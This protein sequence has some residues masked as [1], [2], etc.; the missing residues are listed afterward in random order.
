LIYDR[1][2]RKINYLRISVTDRCNLRCIYCMPEKGI[3]KIKHEDMLSFE[4]IFE[5]TK[6]AVEMGINKVRLTGGEPLIRRDIVVL[7][8]MLSSI[9][10]IKDLAMTTNGIILDKYAL[11]LLKAG[12]QRVNISLDTLDPQRYNE[13]TCGGDIR[14]VL[15]GIKAAKSVGLIPIKLNCVVKKSSDENDA[16]MVK[17]FAKENGLKA[18]F[19]RQMNMEKGLFWP[20]EGGEGGD[21]KRCNRLRLSSDGRIFPCLFND[22]SFSIKE[23]GIEQAIKMAVKAKPKS[24]LWSNHN[25]LGSLGG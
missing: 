6:K 8:S 24:G 21:C 25:N 2:N 3:D 23:L 7:V 12:L 19:I 17:K 16:R 1:F 18:R 20:V 13:I 22:I 11:A 9:D 10:G 5:F 15:R 14:Y 4:E